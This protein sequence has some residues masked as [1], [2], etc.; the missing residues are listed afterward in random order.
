LLAL[1][2]TRVLLLLAPEGLMGANV[3]NADPRILLFALAA[4]ILTALLFGVVPALA[5]VRTDVNETLKEGGKTSQSRGRTRLR[6]V[7]VVAEVALAFVLLVGSG[8]LVRSFQHLTAVDP[9]FHSGNLLAVQLSLPF[10]RYKAETQRVNFFREARDRFAA[11]PGVREA[12]G[13]SFLPFT[14]LASG[15]DIQVVGR[16]A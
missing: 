16:P 3:V 8:L 6:K 4:S 14:G 2:G 11:I 13:N 12:G 1:W 7:F 15:T 9:G 10:S 5:A